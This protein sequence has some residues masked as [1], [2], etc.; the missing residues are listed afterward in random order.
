VIAP[1]SVALPVREGQALGRVE[2]YQ[3]GR[4]VASANLVAATAVSKPGWAGKAEWYVRRTAQ[5]F[6]GL[7]T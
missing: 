7:F 6:G 5:K 2:V 1:A 4:V 3:G